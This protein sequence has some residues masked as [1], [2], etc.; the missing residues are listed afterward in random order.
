MTQAAFTTGIVSLLNEATFDAAVRALLPAGAV[1]GAIP[2][3][4]GNRRVEQIASQYPACWVVEQGD[5]RVS[6]IADETGLTIGGALQQFEG[7]ILISLVWIEQE[8]AAAVTAKQALP[9]LVTQ[10]L[11]RNPQPGGISGAWLDTWQSDRGGNAPV[12]VWG[13]SIAGTYQTPRA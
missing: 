7:A 1:T 11:L 6:P 5:G 10:L 13:A 2:V 8:P 4:L 12:Q 9:T 3:L